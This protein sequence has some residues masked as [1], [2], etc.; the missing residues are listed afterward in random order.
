MEVQLL[1][2][3]VLVGCLF[4]FH[5]YLKYQ[6]STFV[7]WIKNTQK[8][9]GRIQGE[10]AR[11]FEIIGGIGLVLNIPLSPIML[12]L[13]MLRAIQI[14]HWQKNPLVTEHGWEYCAVLIGILLLYI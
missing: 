8:P 1:L 11:A 6:D 7:T 2:L 9:F 12:I 5:G 3:R 4:I 13:V 14:A 10:L